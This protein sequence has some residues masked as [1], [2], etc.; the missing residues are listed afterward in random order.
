MLRLAFYDY[1]FTTPGERRV[2]GAWWHRERL[3]ELTE[4]LR[5]E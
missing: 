2:N 3:G 1:R 4:P 5:V